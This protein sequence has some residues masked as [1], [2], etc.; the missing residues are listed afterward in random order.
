MCRGEGGAGCVEGGR[1]WVCR[2]EGG[3]GCVEGREQ[4]GV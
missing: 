1:R 3:G 2:R 4:V